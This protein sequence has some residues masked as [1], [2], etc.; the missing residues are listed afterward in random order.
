MLLNPALREAP[1]SDG[2]F[3]SNIHHRLLRVGLY[4]L[5]LLVAADVSM[6]S[7]F[8][9]APGEGHE[10]GHCPLAAHDLQE[11]ME[12]AYHALSQ[13]RDDAEKQGLS[14]SGGT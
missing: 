13:R 3:T 4:A 12:H 14:D 9:A 1:Y 6:A 5:A 2:M 11:H 7:V 8:A 10:E